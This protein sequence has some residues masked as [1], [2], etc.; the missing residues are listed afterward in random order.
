LL[1]TSASQNARYKFERGFMATRRKPGSDL[2]KSKTFLSEG[3]S[4]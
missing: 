1:Q 4:R 2:P 3:F